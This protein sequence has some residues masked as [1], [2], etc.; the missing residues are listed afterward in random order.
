MPS[1]NE[2]NPGRPSNDSRDSDS[3]NHESDSRAG[4]ITAAR[5]L[6]IRLPYRSVTLRLIAREARVDP[7]LIR[8]YFGNKAGLFEAMMRESIA[9]VMQSMKQATTSATGVRE[10][11]TTYYRVMGEFPDLPRLVFRVL[12]EADD[13]ESFAVLN[14]VFSDLIR[15]SGQWL[16][17]GLID[18]GLL[19]DDTDPALA[20]LSYISLM[21]FPL[22]APRPILNKLGVRT[23]AEHLNALADHNFNVI[24]RG[25]IN[26]DDFKGAQP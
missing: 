4:L 1:H 10:L 25:L 15:L 23:D 22:I 11:M 5:E 16:Q 13:L 8:Y 24:S 6:F 26:V 19:R 9:P 3:D 20:R 7:A 12:N 2:R 14:R 17:S 18:T 21:V